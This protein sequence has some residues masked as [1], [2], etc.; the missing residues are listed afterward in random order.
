[1]TFNK[2][3]HE[4]VNSI[5][6]KKQ[7]DVKGKDN[8]FYSRLMSNI[9]TIDHL[10]REIYG[11]GQFADEKYNELIVTLIEAHQKRE[12]DLRD[13]DEEKIEK[14]NWFLSN[15]ITGMSLYV[16]RFC[17]NLKSLPEKLTYFENLGVNFLHLMPIFESPAG[18]SDG[19]YAVSN[20]RKIDSR[21]GNI[22]DLISL[23]KRMQKKDMYL[24]IDIVLNHTSHHHEW[25][26]KAKS[27]EKKYQDYYYMY[28]DRWIPNQYDDKMPDIS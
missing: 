1:M 13:R 11:H 19:G 14:G 7:V 20:F 16:D 26:K 12:N 6:D 9:D 27:G 5:I 2:E 21:F 23:R 25:A 18:E 4:Y 3:L 28:D 10:Y 17:E 15:E 22:E 24:M 8:V